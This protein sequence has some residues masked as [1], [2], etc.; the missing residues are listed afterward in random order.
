MNDSTIDIRKALQAILPEW[1]MEHTLGVQYTATALAMCHDVDLKAAS[2]AGLL[3]DCAKAVKKQDKL[4]ECRE[5]GIFISE[6][7]YSNPDMLH[8]KLGAFYAQER[9]GVDDQDILN[10][11]RYHTTGRPNMSLLEK[12]IYIADYIEPNRS[13]APNLHELRKLAFVDLNRCLVAILEQTVTYLEQSGVSIDQTSMDAYH[14][15]KKN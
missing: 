11:I 5:H 8:G 9:Y 14:Y 3:H 12:I 1:R 10:A 4:S 6:Y 13:T 7:E 15:Y 2:L